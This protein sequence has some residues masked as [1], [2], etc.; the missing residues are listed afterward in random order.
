MKKIRTKMHFL[1][2]VSDVAN[3]YRRRPK[4]NFNYILRKLKL[5]TAPFSQNTLPPMRDILKRTIT[6]ISNSKTQNVLFNNFFCQWTRVKNLFFCDRKKSD[7]FCFV[8]RFIAFSVVHWVW[9]MML[10]GLKKMY[11]IFKSHSFW[12][13]VSSLPFLISQFQIHSFCLNFSIFKKHSFRLKWHEKRKT[14]S[15]SRKKIRVSKIDRTTTNK[16][17]FNVFMCVCV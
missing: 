4:N 8:F 1:Y 2:I 17:S 3:G 15:K 6:Q 16:S 11:R 10:N 14:K 7:A 9:C 5:H 13:R 12:C